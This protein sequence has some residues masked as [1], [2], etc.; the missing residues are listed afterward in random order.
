MTDVTIVAGLGFGDEGKGTIVDA[1]TRRHDAKLVV[2]F[3]GGSQAGHNVVTPDGRHHC[4]SQWGSGT[5][6]GTRTL[7][8]RHMLINPIFALSE[9]KH[10]EEVG[11]IDPLSLLVMEADAIVTTPFHVAA[12]RLRELSRSF[13]SGS[14][15][16]SC[17]M[18]IGE[19]RMDADGGGQD[20]IRA[21]M[22]VG[23]DMVRTRLKQCQE[24]K[25]A[26]LA[27]L[28]LDPTNAQVLIEQGILSD[29]KVVDQTV[30]AYL[31]FARK[32]ENG[33]V[34]SAVWL[35]S[36]RAQGKLGHVIFEGAQG[37]LLDEN[38]GFH[39]HTT[40]SD[41][42][43]GNAME[44]L[45]R[46]HLGSVK[47]LGVLRVYH[48]RHGAGPFPSEA[49]EF[50]EFSKDDHNKRHAWQGS[51]RS[52]AFDMVLARYALDVVGG[53]DG[54]A[55][56]HLDKLH[57]IQSVPVCWGHQAADGRVAQ[58]IEPS[59][60]PDL[61]YQEEL[62]RILKGSKALCNRVTVD[63]EDGALRHAKRLG[64]ALKVPVTV[65]S[66]GPTAESKRFIESGSEAA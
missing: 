5:F 10:L 22:L 53:C 13:L 20:L 50:D 30:E 66:S 36:Q 19:T 18:G 45:G 21:W 42:T 9:A 44:L 64:E 48:T 54:L 40:W 2:R 3:N 59:K 56:T 41:C 31:A 1:L 16:G 60:K 7:L 23:T 52:G 11:V 34:R 55:L 57:D 29:P 62:G 39:P 37:V 14:V 17:G 43:F 24:R 26:Q 49:P 47:R 15:H 46:E 32:V 38:Y 25:R 6:A 63:G 27:D 51:F 4:F 65:V 33:E 61:A 28:P 12:N 35:N 8:S 58:I